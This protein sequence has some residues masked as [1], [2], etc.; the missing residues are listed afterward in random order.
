MLFCKKKSMKKLFLTILVS[1]SFLTAYCQELVQQFN[2]TV[3]FLY[4]FSNN[5]FKPYGTAFLVSIP[6]KTQKGYYIY[7]VTAKHVL[8]TENK[9]KLNLIYARFNTKDSSEMFNVPLNWTGRNKTVFTHADTSIDL[10]IIPIVVPSNL[11]YKHIGIDQIIRRSDFDSL[12]VNVGTDVFFTGLFTAYIR[13][14]SINPIFR[15][16]KVCLIPREKIEFDKV[17]RELLLIESSSFGG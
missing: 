5:E 6:A 16:G 2:K 10:A 14:K 12:K 4:A 8:Q 13:T 17:N 11:E 15:F 1:F 7:L 3:A 9:Q